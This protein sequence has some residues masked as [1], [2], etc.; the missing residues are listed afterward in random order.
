MPEA[1]PLPSCGTEEEAEEAEGVGWG[2]G[3]WSAPEA[4]TTPSPGVILPAL[5]SLWDFREPLVVG[6]CLEEPWPDGPGC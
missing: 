1:P 6:G 3:T 4:S 5:L 2:A